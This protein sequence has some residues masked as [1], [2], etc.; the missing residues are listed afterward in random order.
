[1]AAQ[2]S[3]ERTSHVDKL[4]ALTQVYGEIVLKAWNE[5]APEIASLRSGS[6]RIR[7]SSSAAAQMN[8]AA[9]QDA[10]LGAASSEV[11]PDRKYAAKQAAA[12]LNCSLAKI[13]KDTASGK[14]PSVRE[15][16]RVFVLG[17]ELIKHMSA[18]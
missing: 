18:N 10:L 1:M 8:G 7:P 12:L 2:T 5:V 9:T 3:R 13:R 11:D 6:T 4:L 14:L 17:S 16:S 15:G